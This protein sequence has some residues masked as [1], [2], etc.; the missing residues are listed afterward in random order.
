[1]VREPC[2]R[3]GLYAGKTTECVW[4]GIFKLNLK[5]M[6]ASFS[7]IFKVER[8]FFFAISIR[9]IF[10]LLVERKTTL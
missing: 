10:L 4:D 1:M 8:C 7:H 9:F 2:F 3:F 5:E 6:P